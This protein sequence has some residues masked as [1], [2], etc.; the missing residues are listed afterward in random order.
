MINTHPF[1]C[2][3]TNEVILF[4]VKYQLFLKSFKAKQKAEAKKKKKSPQRCSPAIFT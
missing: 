4:T 2:K 1:L 3:D